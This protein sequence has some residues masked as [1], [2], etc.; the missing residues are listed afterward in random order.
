MCFIAH[1]SVLVMVAIWVA[2]TSYAQWQFQLDPSFRTVATRLHVSS[3]L[4]L[5]NGN[6]IASGELKFPNDQNDI[7][8]SGLL[9][10]GQ[11]D[12]TFNN[13]ALGLGKIV[14]WGDGFYVGSNTIV[15]RVLLPSGEND[16]NF[17]LGYM[18]QP[19]FLSLQG[20]GYHVYPDGRLLMSG[21]HL[22]RD[23]IRGFEGLYN[24]IW[25]TNTGYLDTTKVHRRGNNVVYRFKELPNGQFI[26]SGTCTVFDGEEVDWI[27]RV[28]ADG[29]T[30]TT[31]RTG[32]FWGDAL[33][34]LPL[35]DGRC[36]VAGSIRRNQAPDD[37]LAVARF[38]PDGS[39]DPNFNIPHFAL[40]GLFNH[41]LG[42]SS[43]GFGPEARSI[44]P[45]EG[46]RM[47]ITGYFGS[48]NGQIRGGICM[49]DSTGALLDAFAGCW[50]SPFIYDNSSY[51]GITGF[52][53]AGDGEH[54]YI[55]GSYRGFNDGITN[56]PEQ[57]F[58]TR[59][60]VTED[61]T[62]VAGS[63]SS[64]VAKFTLHPNPSNSS[65]I[66]DMNTPRQSDNATVLV[67]DLA[68]RVQDQQYIMGGLGRLV[69]ETS[70]L[71][72]GTYLVTLKVD[73]MT[74]GTQ[75]LVVQQ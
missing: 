63:L 73:G 64:K 48:V 44:T 46:G 26:C 30:D 54:Y 34:Y 43:S 10:D 17:R 59:L 29:T 57:R 67:H 28:N 27:F 7:R 24:L 60:R 68:G 75:R 19:Y 45:W 22:L 2:I 4:P 42:V 69:L 36:Y 14:P 8:L 52:V 61:H 70:H 1:R 12:E 49:L 51:G 3:I 23:S 20:G 5:E 72:A 41:G 47:I 33:D 58:V 11:R 56:D 74:L 35:A 66:F 37:T 21:A 65:V 55:H 9:S 53:P 18:A 15:R 62:D 13:S 50:A 40:N 32:V 71:A 25:F 31:F 6:V 16:Q 39:L 38:M